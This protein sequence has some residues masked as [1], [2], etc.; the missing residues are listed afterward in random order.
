MNLALFDL[1]FTL[2]PIDSDDAW[3]EFLIRNGRHPD[4]DARTRLDDIMAR[5]AAGTLLDDDYHVFMVGSLSHHPLGQL[6]QW[7]ADYMRE[8]VHPH[9][10]PSALALVSLHLEAQDLCCI[11]TGT[12][13]FVTTPIARAFDIPHLLGTVPEEDDGGFTGRVAGVPCTGEGKI[14]HVD[15]WLARLGFEWD[16]FETT[17]F[18]SDS[19]ADVPLLSRVQ[20]PVATNPSASLESYAK[21]RGWPVLRLFE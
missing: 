9:V 6:E 15:A 11:V 12:N 10:L 1:D 18:Y 14:A 21:A 5:H 16:D 20:S 17:T 8:V 3:V 4:P 2:L 19:M 13:T 7:H